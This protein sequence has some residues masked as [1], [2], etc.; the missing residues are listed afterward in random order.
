[1]SHNNRNLKEKLLEDHIGI[2]QINVPGNRS[3]N[4]PEALPAGN[5]P[6]G[7]IQA[8][9]IQIGRK[10][11]S[12]KI[13]N[14]NAPKGLSH[15]RGTTLDQLNLTYVKNSSKIMTLNIKLKALERQLESYKWASND[16]YYQSLEE[17][18]GVQQEYQLLVQE[19]NL[20]KNEIEY[21]ENIKENRGK[22]QKMPKKKP[23]RMIRAKMPKVK[24]MKINM[25]EKLRA[26]R[27]KEKWEKKK[28]QQKKRK[29]CLICFG[30]CLLETLLIIFRILA[31]IAIQSLNSS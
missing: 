22:T 1:M 7:S 19:Q 10:P 14:Q 30:K 23:T 20:I 21:Q 29:E 25:R 26:Q 28:L 27:E 12:I 24:V 15:I 6:I 11:S 8:P 5:A 16:K 31:E 2:Q 18:I 13:Q 3:T 4:I 17:K 9:K